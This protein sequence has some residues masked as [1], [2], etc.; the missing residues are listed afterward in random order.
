V[1]VGWR[2]TRGGR[3]EG[4]T[5]W[6]GGG[7][8]VLVGWRGTRVGRVEGHSWRQQWQCPRGEAA[9]AQGTGAV[10]K[11]EGGGC[12]CECVEGCVLQG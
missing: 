9:W 3:V 11:T 8:H 1:L 2:G 4:H 10:V 7:A 12:W 6:S 5:W